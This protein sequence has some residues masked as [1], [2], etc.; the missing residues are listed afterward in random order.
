MSVKVRDG[1]RVELIGRGAGG[2]GGA[3]NLPHIRLQL[4]HGGHQ[5]VHLQ[6]QNVEWEIP[7]T[8][9]HMREKNIKGKCGAGIVYVNYTI[10]MFYEKNLFI[11]ICINKY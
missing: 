8:L 9:D 10:M 7:W 2:D 3:L 5:R 6:G 11:L 4:G 1:H